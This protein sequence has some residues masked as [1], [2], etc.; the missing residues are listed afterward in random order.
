MKRK[1]PIQLHRVPVVFGNESLLPIA[2]HSSRW[3]G[4]PRALDLSARKHE[5]RPM[6]S[7]SPGGDGELINGSSGRKPALANSK[8]SR[9][10][11]Q[12]SKLNSRHSS[13]PPRGF[14]LVEI[15]VVLLLLSLI[16]F[17]LMAVFSSTQRAFRA[18]L[19]QTD[20]LENGRAVMDLIAGDLAAMT[21]CDAISNA[22]FNPQNGNLTV[23]CP[24][25]FSC[26]VAPPF[27]F[28]PSPLFQ[29]LITSPTGSQVTNLLENIFILSRGNIAGVPSWIATG[30]SVNT[31]LPD[32]T[33]YPLYRF[34]MT[35]NMVSG[36]VGLTNLYNT[37]TQFQYTDSTNWSHLM[38]GVV[39]L[40]VRAFDTNGVWLTNGYANPF[41]VR[42]QNVAFYSSGYGEVNCLF[43][44]NAVPASVQIELG[45]LEDRV[46]QHAEGL[47]GLNQSNYLAGAAGQVHLFRQRVWI[48]NFDPT[49]YQ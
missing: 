38:D 47:S 46:L 10:A 40:T 33:L 45:T 15:L 36:A 18:S 43:F 4:A 25:N 1:A 16:I 22:V 41:D 7:P 17:A 37:F 26:V 42:V 23:A 39:N 44:S 20:S 12:N 2:V 3:T 27:A 35:T 24:V 29:S 11:G 5:N 13:F 28:P 6:A 21:P 30:Y 31:N 19:T 32:G 48:R 49:A 14:T 34:Y 9:I 8:F